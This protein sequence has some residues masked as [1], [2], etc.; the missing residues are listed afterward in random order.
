MGLHWV[1]ASQKLVKPVAENTNY[2]TVLPF[3]CLTETSGLIVLRNLSGYL[4]TVSAVIR[5]SEPANC[6]YHNIAERS[7][8]IP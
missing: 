4:T 2:I 5:V 1:S 6:I 7:L 3:F 8:L